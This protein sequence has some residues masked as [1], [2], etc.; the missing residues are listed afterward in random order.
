[1]KATSSYKTILFSVVILMVLT[2]ILGYRFFTQHW[3]VN[4]TTRVTSVQLFHLLHTGGDFPWTMT[5]TFRFKT[6][7]DPL[8]VQQKFC[9]QRGWSFDANRSCQSSYLVDLGPLFYMIV[10][11]TAMYWRTTPPYMTLSEAYTLHK[12]EP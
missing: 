1:M 10:S 8:V 11:K 7:E 3:Y 9:A 6:S 5:N 2:V 12:R 4:S